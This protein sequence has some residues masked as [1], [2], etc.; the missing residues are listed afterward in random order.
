MPVA[1]RIGQDEIVARRIEQLPLAEKLAG[2]LR[3][4]K[5]APFAR[6]SV[7]DQH[8]V[9]NDALV[10]ALRTAERA[11]VHPQLGQS[12]ARREMKVAKDEVAGLRSRVIGRA[13]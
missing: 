6:G 13:R 9:A 10:V 7:H 12:F 3:P 1:D 5:V 8:R 4:Q 2:K 11:I